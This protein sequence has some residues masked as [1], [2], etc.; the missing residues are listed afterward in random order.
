MKKNFLIKLMFLTILIF[1]TCPAFSKSK[2]EILKVYDGDSA[3]AKIDKNIFRIRLVG[4]D[5]FEGTAG[6]RAKYQARAF[7]KKESEIIEGG[8]IAGEILRGE[9]RRS[10][11]KAEFEF[12]GIDRYNRALGVLYV[13]KTNLNEKMLKTPYCAPYNP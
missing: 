8:N 5:C 12:Y 11:N 1:S 10:S 4:I 6:K 7:N 2:V 3:L 9:L 13:G